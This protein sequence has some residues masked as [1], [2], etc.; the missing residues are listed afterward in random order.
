MSKESETKKNSIIKDTDKDQKNISIPL[1]MNTKNK[2]GG[3][4]R[5]LFDLNKIFQFNFSYNFDLLKTLLESIIKSQK[6][7]EEEIINL[8]Q[9]IKKKDHKIQ[10][11][12]KNL[13]DVNILVSTSTGDE[14]TVKKLME[15]KAKIEKEKENENEIKN[16]ETIKESDG[17]IDDKKVNTDDSNTDKGNNKINNNKENSS[18]YSLSKYKK[19]RPPSNDI[20]IEPGENN[21]ELVNKIIVSKIFFLF[22]IIYKIYFFEY[23]RKK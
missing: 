12:E 4:N 23:Y 21:N 10:E 17:E 3:I 14:E 19:I 6:T 16:T 11:L 22:F 15:S 5:S 18:Q 2:E 8:K 20:K 7:T 13:I 9:N 1:R